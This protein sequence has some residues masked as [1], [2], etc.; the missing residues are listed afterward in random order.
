M[1]AVMLAT[2]GTLDA[3]N[4]RQ[5]TQPKPKMQSEQDALN[6]LEKAKAK[7]DRKAAKRRNEQQ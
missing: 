7:R 3:F 1:A 2:V 4:F 6:R 5:S